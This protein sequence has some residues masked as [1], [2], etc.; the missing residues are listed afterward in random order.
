MSWWLEHRFRMIQNNLRDIDAAMDVDEEVAWLLRLHANVVQLGCGGITAFSEMHLASQKRSP[1]LKED[2]FGALLKK[3]HEN[4]IR[5][6]ARFD[7]SKVD[8]SF[9]A[10]HPEWLLK[11]ANGQTL[12]YNDTVVTC[13]NGPYQQEE[14]PGI[15]REILLKYPVDGVF[16]NMFGYQERDY[17]GNYFG[18]CQCES[19][20]KRFRE[21]FGEALP[22]AGER[23]GE[24]F[25]KYQEFKRITVEEILKKIRRT[26]KEVRPETALS[27]YFDKHVD[28]IRCETNTAVDRP[29][30]FW[31]YSASDNVSCIENT[32]RDKVSSNVGIN[33]VDIPYRFTGVS[34]TFNR[35][36]LYQ[37]I[38]NRGNLDW[39]I[40]G[41]F[42]DYPDRSNFEGVREVFS[43]HERYQELYDTMKSAA[44]VLLVSPAAPYRGNA[45]HEYRGIFRML[46][47]AHVL[48]DTVIDT[49]SEAYAIDPASYDL[50]ILPGIPRL[51]SEK[52]RACFLHA[53]QRF[54]GT[55]G[56]LSEDPALLNA[57]FGIAS[58]QEKQAVRG[59]Y[60]ATEPK[61]IFRS[62]PEQD[63]IYVD[64]RRWEAEG[65]VHLLPFITPAPYGP[66]ERCYGHEKTALPGV[67]SDGRS[68]MI[69]FEPGTL[70]DLQGFDFYRKLFTDLLSWLLP[71]ERQSPFETD[72]HPKTEIFF[73]R[74]D[75]RTALLELI[76]LTGF[77]GVTVHPPV[78]QKDVCIRFR[79]E[80]EEVQ[81]LTEE[82]PV[83]LSFEGRQ[84]VIR[85][86]GL[87]KAY[88]IRFRESCC[89]S[90]K[91]EKI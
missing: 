42:P 27:T 2:K 4:G 44:H 52:L 12:H 49:D 75:T 19:C 60:Y 81:E 23:T 66:P 84:F 85:E 53:G 74:L 37:N 29:L 89:G 58:L 48:F 61:E 28:I 83:P 33:A 18:P 14:I 54:I 20:R 79:Q 17:D 72:A 46:K 7:A 13:L 39:C 68:A 50:V 82:G 8:Q 15:L 57:L 55:A 25:E 10:L 78:V 26:V 86:L 36:R 9:E 32:F 3:C 35:T 51:R 63:W 91:E 73:N 41:A 65:P 16:F 56:S 40:I 64:R 76:S 22:A 70:Y 88:R 31:I 67:V 1:W 24:R 38:A 77:E 69:L 87:H 30:P 34:D 43:Y 90:S 45:G 6:I 11:N 80:I 47:E 5:V 62:F 71:G 59:A 21:M